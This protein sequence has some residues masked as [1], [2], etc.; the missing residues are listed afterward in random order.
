MIRFFFIASTIFIFTSPGFSQEWEC[1]TLSFEP[2][3]LH[4]SDTAKSNYLDTLDYQWFVGEDSTIYSYANYASDVETGVEE[5]D[6][7]Y[8]LRVLSIDAAGFG[9]FRAENYD[10][11]NGSIRLVFFGSTGNYN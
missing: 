10:R 8:W 7:M 3:R 5:Y 11:I 2:F 1:D 9:D 4:Y 6:I